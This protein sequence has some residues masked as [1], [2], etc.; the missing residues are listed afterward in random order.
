MGFGPAPNRSLLD[1]MSQYGR[2][3]VNYVS[4][5]G[6]TSAVARRFNDRIHSP[7]LTDISIEWSDLPVTDVYPKR[8]PDLF[9]ARPLIISGRYTKGGKGSIWLKGKMAGQD[10][11]REIPMELPETET[12]HDV[13]ANLW[14]RHRIDDLVGEEIANAQNKPMQ[15]QVRE[16]ITQLGLEF[17][18]MTQYTSFVA[19][20]EKVFT[21]P[22]DPVRVNVPVQS[23]TTAGLLAS[24]TVMNSM[25]ASVVVASGTQ[26]CL[27]SIS[28]ETLP[29]QGRSVT[30]LYLLTP[31]VVPSSTSTSISVNGQRPSSNT[32]TLD[33]VDA[34]FG[35]APGGESPG[36]S[37]SGNTP[38]LTASGG[39]NSLVTLEAAQEIRVQNPVTA[40]E[41]G[42]VAGGQIEL[43]TRSGTNEYHGSLF[44]FFGNDALD[45]NDWFANSR[46]LQ[47]PAKRLNTFGGIVWRA[48]CQRQN[49]LL[50]VLRRDAFA[51]ADG[52]HHRRAFNRIARR[53]RC[54]H[55]TI[56]ERVSGPEWRVAGRW[57]RGV[58]GE[59]FKSCAT[60]RRQHQPRS[61]A[62]RENDA[63]R[64]L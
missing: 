60:R 30:A 2:G 49:V 38:A 8:I 21:G 37:A 43:V 52:R 23:G 5:V 50:C 51:P 42:S 9:S 13:L 47:Q 25:T 45:A 48:N 16:E 35:I 64:S 40:A 18:L 27:V 14:A 17:K 53:S 41:Y 20:D 58:C 36:T 54:R 1:R 31:G 59:F 39:A 19:I 55:A 24:V 44:H 10:F 33:G 15:D 29:I 62:E 56:P 3:E 46:G 32:L 61:F 22:E 11:V 28:P 6:N 26:N 34:N 7:L 57:L 4:E 63:A 12:D